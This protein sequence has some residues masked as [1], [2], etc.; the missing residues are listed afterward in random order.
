MG[1]EAIHAFGTPTMLKTLV[2]FFPERL[3]CHPCFQGI[4]PLRPV[5][6][7]AVDLFFYIDCHLMHC[8]ILG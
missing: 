4:R 2:K 8:C 5:A 3:Q 7:L 1:L 6:D